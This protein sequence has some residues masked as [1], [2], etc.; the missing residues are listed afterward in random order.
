MERRKRTKILK[1]N[2]E[3]VICGGIHFFV[4][5]VYFFELFIIL[6]RIYGHGFESPWKLA[7]V[8]TGT[9]ILVNLLIS[10]WKFL[11]TDPGTGSLILPSSLQKGWFYCWSC[12]ANAPPR[13]FHCQRCSTCVLV[14][15]HHCIISSNCLGHTTRRYFL[16]MNFYF[17]VALLYANILNMDFA[18]EI[19]HAFNFKMLLVMFVPGVAWILGYAKNET[20]FM[21]MVTTITLLGFIYSSTVFYFHARNTIQGITTHEYKYKK[22]QEYN[23]GWRKNLMNALGINWKFCWISPLVPSPLPGDGVNFEV[24][25]SLLNNQG[26]GETR[27]IDKSS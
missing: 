2:P 3:K 19:Y 5:L 13:S 14:R 1:T 7:H 15:D 27:S 8:F 18:W 23:L 21:M 17:W 9:W 4:V 11:L 12:E 16:L 10:Y 6:P 20:F 26:R 24:A 25:A 22:G